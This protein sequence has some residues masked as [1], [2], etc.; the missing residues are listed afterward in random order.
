MIILVPELGGGRKG[1]S[2]VTFDPVRVTLGSAV[3]LSCVGEIN[4]MNSFGVISSSLVWCSLV[5]FWGVAS[6]EM[7]LVNRI[8][9]TTT[10]TV[11]VMMTMV[12][13]WLYLSRSLT[14]F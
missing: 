12:T 11:T 13:C 6:L 1:G 4:S 10:T 2:G 14:V 3:V 5:I 7:I 8:S 9:T